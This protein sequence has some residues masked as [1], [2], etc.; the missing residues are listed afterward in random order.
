MILNNYRAMELIGELKDEELSPALVVHIHRTITD[1]TLPTPDDY[2]RREGDG[3]G[4][5]DNTNNVLLH[6]PP[7]A[8]EIPERMAGMCDFANEAQTGVFLHPVLKATILHFWLAYD[9]PFVDGNGRTA[10]ALFYWLMLRQDFWLFEFISISTILKKAPARY[11]RS[12]L[13]TET[14]EN[15]LTYFILSQL[16]VICRAIDE[17][18]AYLVR[19]IAEI[20]ETAELLRQSSDLNHRQL[21]LL[22]H[23]LKHPGMRY[24]IRSHQTSHRVAYQTSRTDLLDLVERQLLHQGRSGRSFVFVAPRDL[25]TRLKEL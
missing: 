9:H 1:G 8:S 4:V 23:A 16:S 13:Y 6:A 14:D 17:L 11:G 20:R 21:A 7:P 3:I 18:R 10:R 19:K 25:S 12:F 15:D 5:Y 22:S 24:T 2:F